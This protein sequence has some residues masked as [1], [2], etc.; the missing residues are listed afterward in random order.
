MAYKDQLHPWCIVR[1][2]PQA[3]SITVAR[4]RRRSEAESH[5][6]ILR[7]ILPTATCTIMFDAVTSNLS[8]L[9]PESSPCVS[10]N[11]EPE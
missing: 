11:G 1:C 4:F 6:Q 8:I 3:R 7:R 10:K 5:L 9:E 2:L